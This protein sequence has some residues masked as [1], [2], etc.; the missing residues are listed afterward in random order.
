M[1]NTELKHH[2]TKGMR[3]GVRRYQNK[4]G[5]LTAAGKKRYNK[6]LAEIKAEKA[7][8]A[9]QKKIV[10]RQLRTRAKFSK[11]DDM[12]EELDAERKALASKKTSLFSKHRK[13]ELTP[14]EIEAKKEAILKSRSPKQL[15]ENAHLFSDKELTNAYNR[16][17]TERNIKNLIPADVKKGEEAVNKILDYGDKAV[18]GLDIGTKL[19][20]NVA[21]IMNSTMD[22][23]LP[24]IKADKK[25]DDKKPNKKN[26]KKDD[27]EEK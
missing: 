17:N 11:L 25:K 1:D 15:Y 2:G 20:N 22:A 5:S 16:L 23:E 9:A 13:K 27:E 3:W 10:E 8:I 7:K 14:E 21:K 6:E 18:K 24:I 26:D 19:Y 4:D 12:R